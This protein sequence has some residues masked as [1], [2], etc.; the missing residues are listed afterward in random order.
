M[1]TIEELTQNVINN[2]FK[3]WAASKTAS[4]K[5]AYDN[6][7][8]SHQQNGT[9]YPS[10]YQVF[11]VNETLVATLEAD[12]PGTTTGTQWDSVFVVTTISPPIPVAPVPGLSLGEPSVEY[13][14]L[15]EMKGDSPNVPIGKQHT[16]PDGHVYQKVGPV[17][18]TPFSPYPDQGVY[19]WQ[20]LS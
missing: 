7:V 6:A 14:G 9:P 13:P 12:A 2:V 16:E 20:P 17:S 10:S 5:L 1:A 8:L 11:G 18:F 3:P 19:L 4:S 15:W